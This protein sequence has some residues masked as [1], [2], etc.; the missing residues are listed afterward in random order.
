MGAL[1]EGFTGTK[2]DSLGRE[3]H[4]VNGKRVASAQDVEKGKAGQ[5]VNHLPHD[6]PTPDHVW[7]AIESALPDELKHTPGILDKVRHVAARA[8]YTV[9][10]AAVEFG[11]ALAPEILDVAQDFESIKYAKMNAQGGAAHDP[12]YAA[13]GVPYSAV[14][15][16]FSKIVGAAYGYYQSKRG[17][18]E[19]VLEAL[20]DDER[21]QVA[22]AVCELFRRLWEA[23]GV[24][25]PAPTVAEVLKRMAERASA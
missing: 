11:P 4:F 10:N 12:F 22:E 17:A 20:G 25:V 7:G 3:Y 2:T 21:Q 6:A 23:L 18:T 24:D 5:P 13:T 1:L 15:A 14:S 16:V 8:Y 9:W 19:S